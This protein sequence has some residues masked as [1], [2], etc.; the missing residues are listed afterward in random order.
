MSIWDDLD[1]QASEDVRI[2]NHDFVVDKI[3]EGEWEPGRA[4]RELDGRLITGDNMNIR[5]RFNVT[6]DE[7]VVAAQISGWDQRT[8]RSVNLSHQND[9]TLKKEYGVTLAEIK[10]GDT[11]RVKTDY[12]TDKKDKEKK[13]VKIIK[14]LPKTAS[15]SSNGNTSDVPF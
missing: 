13:Y 2:G 5:Q 3:T 11:F 4:Y 9:E 10:E 12:E 15:L 14:F 1:K 7:A 6:P 8:K